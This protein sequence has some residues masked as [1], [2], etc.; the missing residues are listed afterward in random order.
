LQF[1]NGKVWIL[2]VQTKVSMG[3]Q[4]NWSAIFGKS[5]ALEVIQVLLRCC[6]SLTFRLPLL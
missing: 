6:K 3:V 2:D 4:Q 5:R 1:K